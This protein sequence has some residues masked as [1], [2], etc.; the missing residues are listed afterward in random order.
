MCICWRDLVAE[1][2]FTL[3]HPKPEEEPPPVAAPQENTTDKTE[4]MDNND[5]NLIQ[6]EYVYILHFVF[7]MIFLNFL[8]RFF[9]PFK[10]I[11]DLNEVVGHFVLLLQLERY[12][13]FQR[14]RLHV[15]LQRGQL[16][17]LLQL[18]RQHYSWFLSVKK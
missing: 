8:L 1:L 16:F 12:L 18:G 7:W 6:L 2:P 3:M 10:T 14:E 13:L 5:T 4:S 11:F 17:L 15:L 9:F